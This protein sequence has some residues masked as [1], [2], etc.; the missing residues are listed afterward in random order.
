MFG[1]NS[2]NTFS[3]FGQQGTQQTST[4]TGS[5]FGAGT[6]VFGGSGF[7]QG[8]SF[9]AGNSVFGQGTQLSS[10]SN[11]NFGGAKETTGF[12]AQTTHA[13]GSQ[14]V[15]TPSRGIFGQNA[16]STGFGN[17]YGSNTFSGSSLNSRVP[18]QG[19]SNP[20]YQVTQEKETSTGGMQYFQ[21]ITCMPAYQAASFE[22][23]RLQDYTQN[24]RFG[25]QQGLFGSFNTGQTTGNIFGSGNQTYTSQPFGDSTV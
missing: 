19:T 10:A 9:G 12:N 14:T 21:S 16:T 15:G 1:Q 5:L 4:G 7:G 3:R 24:R 22:E 18:T 11:F 13:F 23:L 8:T 6:G 25:Q 20:P 17:T 2:G